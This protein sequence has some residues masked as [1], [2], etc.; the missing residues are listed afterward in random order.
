[1]LSIIISEIENCLKKECYF[2]ALTMTLMLPYICGK[3]EYPLET[4]SHKRY[5][6]W[7]QKH[8]GQYHKKFGLSESKEFAD[9]P[10]L[11]D[12]VIYSLRCSFLHSGVTDIEGKIT[13]KRNMVSK[14]VLRYPPRGEYDHYGSTVL[15]GYS[16]DG[17][18]EI[19][20]YTVDILFICKT[21]CNAAKSYFEENSE[22]FNFFSNNIINPNIEIK[23]TT[24]LKS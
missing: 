20:E 11:S 17:K 9:Q 15:S 21:I 10:Y 18:L 4:S 24:E 16:N 19:Q 23:S 1:M 14:F 7:Y 5:K 3:A 13:E 2:A 6:D 22:K 12:E 8:I